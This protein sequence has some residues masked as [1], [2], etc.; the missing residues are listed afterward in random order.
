MDLDS[1]E[2]IESQEV[3]ARQILRPFTGTWVRRS[4]SQPREFSASGIRKVLQK[5]FPQRR[6]VLSQFTFFN[7]IGVARPNGSTFKRGR[8]CYLL[9]DILPIA[10]VLALKEEG[11]PLKNIECVPELIQERAKDIFEKGPGCWLAGHG[12]RI[13]LSMPGSDQ[14]N[15]ALEDFLDT[16][17]SS[18]LF[19]GVDVGL[20]ALQIDEIVSSLT[21]A[22]AQAA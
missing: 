10:V 6:L 16:E 18:L 19:W 17:S 4:L 2:D 8:R 9:G 11:I 14:A 3:G 5:L 7:Q 12:E 13:S 1:I 22:E 20:L 21:Q 15:K